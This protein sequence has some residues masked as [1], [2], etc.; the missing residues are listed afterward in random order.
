C[1][2]TGVWKDRERESIPIKNHGYKEYSFF[3]YGKKQLFSLLKNTEKRATEIL[4]FCDLIIKIVMENAI[5]WE[6]QKINILVKKSF[7]T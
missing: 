5:F 3:N 7:V 2:A 6:A 1:F 4:M